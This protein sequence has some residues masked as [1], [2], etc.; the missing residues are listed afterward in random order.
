MRGFDEALARRGL[1]KLASGFAAL[2][3]LSAILIVWRWNGAVP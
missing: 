1:L 3:I 2:A